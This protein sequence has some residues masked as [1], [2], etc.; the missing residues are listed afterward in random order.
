MVNSSQPIYVGI[1][2]LGPLFPLAFA[3]APL[4]SAVAFFLNARLVARFGMRRLSHGSMIAFVVTAAVWFTVNLTGVMPLWLFILFMGIAM[5]ALS[6]GW[7]NVPALM[8]EPL[9]DVAGTASA[10]FGSLSAVGAAV[11]GFAVAQVFDGT[12]T[13][14]IGSLLL[15]GVIVVAFF[16]VAERGRLFG[17]RPIVL[18]A[19]A[20]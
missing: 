18:P 8:M 10:V 17:G 11:L 3:V 5:L 1:Y 7:G 12:T 4:V 2:G 19:D 16:A 20:P 13:P 14:F 15:F 9:G 6:L